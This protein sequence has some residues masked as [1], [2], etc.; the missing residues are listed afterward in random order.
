[1]SFKVAV[2]AFLASVLGVLVTGCASPCEEVVEQCVA[3][4]LTEDQCT[5]FVTETYQD[6]DDLCDSVL[7]VRLDCPN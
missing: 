7:D 3:C 2:P 4:G 5:A 1:M 6:D